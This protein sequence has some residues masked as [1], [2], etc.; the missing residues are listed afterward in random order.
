MDIHAS[1]PV[2]PPSPARCPP[3][4]AVRVPRL[5]LPMADAGVAEV[6]WEEGGKST[7]MG[8]WGPTKDA[9]LG[10]RGVGRSLLLI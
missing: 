4:L 9:A 2:P 10:E 6:V 8:P 3:L 1:R 7:S 5:L